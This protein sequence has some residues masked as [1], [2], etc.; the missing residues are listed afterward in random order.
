[1]QQENNQCNEKVDPIRST[2]GKIEKEEVTLDEK[3]DFVKTFARAHKRFRFRQLLESQ[4]S[5]MH[6]VVSFLAILELMKVGEI[7]VEQEQTFDD[8]WITSAV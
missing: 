7:E 1:M 5:K 4:K 2:F 8:I 6:I 3:L